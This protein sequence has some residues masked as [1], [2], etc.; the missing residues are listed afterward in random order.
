MKINALLASSA[1]LVTS[2]LLPA[3]AGADIWFSGSPSTGEYSV[4]LLVGGAP[5]PVG[6]LSGQAY[7]EGRIGERYVIRV[8]NRSWRRVEAV[9]SVDGRD[10]IDGRD[11]QLHKRGYVIP[12]YSFIDV[13]GFR[14]NRADVASFRFTTVP[15]SYTARMGTPWKVG[16]V[17]V[18]IFPEYVRPQP[19][20]RPRPPYVMEERGRPGDWDA[21]AEAPA[22]GAAKSMGGY[23]DDGYYRGSARN[24]GTEFGERRYSPVSE[25]SFT[26]ENW[27]SPAARLGLRY[28]DRRGLC[29]LGLGAFCYPDYPPEPYY[30]PPRYDDYSHPPPGWEHFNPGY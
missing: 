20:P 28:D 14:L 16:V 1:L 21:A 27:G 8:H 2:L 25:T 22:A 19:R 11:A 5:V 7:A 10:A 17:G 12:A 9:I 18:A 23:G 4:E 13:D 26:R 30:P 6:W 3:D 15:D 24:L 29:N